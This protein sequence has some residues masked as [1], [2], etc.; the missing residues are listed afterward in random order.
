[1]SLGGGT[2]LKA[3]DRMAI[4][5]RMQEVMS[6][7][8]PEAA[9]EAQEMRTTAEALAEEQRARDAQTKLQHGA[10]RGA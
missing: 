9:A 3:K 4:S 8:A 5:M 1:M 2:V 10:A 7:M 6:E